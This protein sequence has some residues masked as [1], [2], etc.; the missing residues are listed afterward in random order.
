MADAAF[1][2]R[3]TTKAHVSAEIGRLVFQ[4]VNG[5]YSHDVA[6]QF[7][8]GMNRVLK[9]TFNPGGDGNGMQQLARS[10]TDPTNPSSLAAIRSTDVANIASVVR[11]STAEAAALQAAS[12]TPNITIPPAIQTR[13]DAMDAAD[14][15]N[16]LTQA[17]IGAK[18]GATEA[19][20]AKVGTRVTD[21]VL[22]TA[23]GTDYKS[24][25][26][27]ELYEL[28]NAVMQNADRPRIRDVHKLLLAAISFNFNFQHRVSDNVAVLRARISRLGSYGITVHDD[29]LAT[30]ILAQ[31]DKAANESWGR[32]IETAVAKLRLRY[33]YE[34]VHDAQSIADILTELAAADSVRNLAAAPAP[35][36]AANGHANVAT[37]AMS[38]V[39]RLIFD[40]DTSEEGTEGTA[41]S[42]AGYNS[43]SSDEKSRRPSRSKTKR[44]G[45]G[46]RDRSKSRNARD[47]Y[48][49]ENNP[50]KHCRK[51]GRRNRHPNVPA[52]SCFWNKKWKGFRPRY[53]CKVMDV[54]YRSRDKFPA[55]L[56]GFEV[57]TDE[58]TSG[59]ESD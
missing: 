2:A 34:R 46:N 6:T 45:K 57:S 26:E 23:D 32:E 51:S 10:S 50:C 41:M 35:S 21:A 42:A 17:V 25:D 28:V 52:E 59:E 39:T 14:R 53:C 3:A 36:A 24:V 19:I 47:D 15:Q 58:T 4:T 27:Y 38:H 16:Q 55:S 7:V 29:M 8:L 5:S 13:A 1:T 54:K 43:D 49:A 44:G 31:V 12:A 18:E 37:D 33:G 9:G 30:I 20:T 40:D 11:E 56:G 48:T 22:R